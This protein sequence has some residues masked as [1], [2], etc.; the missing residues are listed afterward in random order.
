MGHQDVEW[1]DDPEE[2]RRKRRGSPGGNKRGSFRAEDRE[3]KSRLQAKR[4]LKP[5]GRKGVSDSEVCLNYLR[6]S[7]NKVSYLPKKIL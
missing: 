4:K 2:E 1:G 7:C 5:A 3:A 6:G